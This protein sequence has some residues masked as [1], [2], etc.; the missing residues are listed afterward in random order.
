MRTWSIPLI[1]VSLLPCSLSLAIPD[2]LNVGVSPSTKAFA[3]F[4]TVK[5][6]EVEST[7]YVNFTEDLF[8][9]S[10]VAIITILS[11]S[12]GTLNS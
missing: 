7:L 8:P 11:F 3:P 4:A 12:S 9:T 10:S 5:L 2:T 1:P 6:G